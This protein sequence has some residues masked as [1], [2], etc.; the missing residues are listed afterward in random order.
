M[1]SLESG[2]LTYIA[3]SVFDSLTKKEKETVEDMTR[4]FLGDYRCSVTSNYPRWLIQPGFSRQTLMTSE[5]RVGSILAL[6]L[7]LQDPTIRETIRLAH[8]RQTQ[9]YLDLSFDLVWKRTPGQV[10]EQPATI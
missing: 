9:K 7:S 6:S 3:E 8:C 4:S 10:L 1:H 5:E 2:M